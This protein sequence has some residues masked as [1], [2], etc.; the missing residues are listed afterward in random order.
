MTPT[1]AAL[2]LVFAKDSACVCLGIS[3]AILR[4]EYNVGNLS[5]WWIGNDSTKQEYF[6]FN[7]SRK[8]NIDYQDIIN[9]L[10]VTIQ[11]VRGNEKFDYR[12]PLWSYV[13]RQIYRFNRK[14]VKFEYFPSMIK[15]HYNKYHQLSYYITLCTNIMQHITQAEKGWL[16]IR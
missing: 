12:V 16:T 14:Y 7:E 13:T 10:H 15:L 5:N 8:Q 6:F 9:M 3:K 2:V 1:S 11:F 4:I